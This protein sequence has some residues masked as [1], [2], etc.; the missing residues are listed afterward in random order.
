MPSKSSVLSLNLRSD[1]TNNLLIMTTMYEE[2]VFVREKETKHHF[3]GDIR[4]SLKM[5][6]MTSNAIN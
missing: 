4:K 3:Q 6:T 2:K 5:M 1:L